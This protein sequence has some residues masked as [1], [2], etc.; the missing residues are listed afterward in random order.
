MEA[1]GVLFVVFHECGFRFDGDVWLLRILQ[2]CIY[3]FFRLCGFF[4][5]IFKTGL[6]I[7]GVG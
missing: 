4:F 6:R 2:T 1:L 7:L 5:L 3:P